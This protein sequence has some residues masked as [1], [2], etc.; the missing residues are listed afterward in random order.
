MPSFNVDATSQAW[1]ARLKDEPR[2]ESRW[3]AL[4]NRYDSRLRVFAAHLMGPALRAKTDPDDV[5]SEAWLRILGGIGDFDY[6]GKNSLYFWLCQQIRR[7]VIDLSRQVERGGVLDALS[8][9]SQVADP[10]AANPSEAA[11]RGELETR[12]AETLEQ[13]PRTY[14]DLLVAR[15]LEEKSYDEISEATGTTQ[16]TLAQKMLRG[17]ELW[18]RALGQDPLA[19]I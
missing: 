5:I 6:R 16:N 8:S 4:S 2:A 17:L 11:A 14:R 12:M 9:S 10:K 3:E 15:L 18:R 1:I 7:I 19:R 13:L